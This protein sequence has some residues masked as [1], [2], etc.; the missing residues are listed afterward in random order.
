VAGMQ[1][2]VEAYDVRR[3]EQFVDVAESSVV[4]PRCLFVDPGIGHQHLEAEGA[5]AAAHGLTDA[6]EPDQTQRPPCEA[7]DVTDLVPAPV[8]AC[9]HLLVIGEQAAVQREQERQRMVRDLLRAV[10]ADA[11]YGDAAC[12]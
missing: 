8:P 3:G 7:L 2:A 6:A 5:D 1:V 9:L 11:A 4:P 10:L 12:G